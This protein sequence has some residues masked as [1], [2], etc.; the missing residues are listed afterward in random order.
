M[1][2]FPNFVFLLL[3]LIL[4]RLNSLSTKQDVNMTDK[5]KIKTYKE[6][7]IEDYVFIMNNFIFFFF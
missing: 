4:K 2:F 7:E 5:A 1:K 6:L 3:A